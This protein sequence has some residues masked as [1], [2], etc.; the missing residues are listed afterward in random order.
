MSPTLLPA[1]P[2]FRDLGQ[3]ASAR[4]HSQAA[5]LPW[6]LRLRVAARA[7]RALLS[8]QTL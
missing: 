1:A 8:N 6:R 5:G 2:T 7:A 3:P 4:M